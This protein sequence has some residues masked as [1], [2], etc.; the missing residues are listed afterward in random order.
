[1]CTCFY[2]ATTQFHPFNG[3]SVCE[4]EDVALKDQH[5]R[6]FWEFL[7]KKNTSFHSNAF[8]ASNKFLF[9]IMRKGL[10]YV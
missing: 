7:L 1:M 3:P 8:V 2:K 4:V 5:T 9:D 6:N 10:R